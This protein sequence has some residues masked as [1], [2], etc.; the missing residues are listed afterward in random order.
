MRFERETNKVVVGDIRIGGNHGVDIVGGFLIVL[1]YGLCRDCVHQWIC[2]ITL[3]ALTID[4]NNMFNIEAEV[5]HCKQYLKK[6][7]IKKRKKRTRE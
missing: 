1:L 2:F 5:V 6:V 4:H 7:I 3:K